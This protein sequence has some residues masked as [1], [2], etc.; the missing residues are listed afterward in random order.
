MLRTFKAWAGSLMAG[1]RFGVLAL[2]TVV[3]IGCSA[4]ALAQTKSFVRDDLA[5]DGVRLEEQLRKEGAAGAVNKQAAQLRRDAEAALA[6]D[7]QRA[8]ALA[9][10]AISADPK[11]APSWLLL[12]RAALAIAPRDNPERWRLQERATVAAYAAYHA[13]QHPAGGGCRA[14]RARRGLRT[15]RDLAARARRLP[16][17][18]RA[19]PTTPAVRTVYEA[20]REEHGFRIADYKVD[21]DAASPRVCFQFSDPLARGKVDFAPFVAVAGAANAAVSVED[22]QLCVDGLK[23]GERYAVVLR[24]GLPSDVG[25]KPAEDRPITRSMSATAPP[26]SASPARTTCCRASGRRASRSSRSTRPSVAAEIFRVGDRNLLSTVRSEDFLAQLGAYRARQFADEN[27]VKIWSGTLDVAQRAQQATS[28]PPFPCMEAVGKLEPGVYVMM[29]RPGR[30]PARV[31]TP[32][33]TTAQR[34]TQWFVVS[35]LGLTAFSG[36]DGVHVLVRSLASAGALDGRRDP[37]RSP[38]TTRCSRRSRPTRTGTSRSIPAWRAARAGLRPA[39][40]SPRTRA[41]DYGFL[42]LGKAAFDLTDRGVKGRDRARAGST[43]SS[44]PSAASIAPARRCISPRCCATRAGVAVA[45]PAADHRRHAARRRR[46]SPRRGRRPGRRADAA[47]RCRCSR[48]RRAARGAL[49]AYADPKGPAI[50]ET[51]FLVE[52]YVPERLERR[53]EAAGSRLC[54]PASP[55]RSTLPCAISTARPAPIS[56]SPANTSSSRRPGPAFPASMATQVGLQDEEFENVAGEIEDRGTTDAQGR[57]TMS[58]DLPDANAPRP[59]EAKIALRVGEAGGRTIERSVVIPIRPQG[60]RCRREEAVRRSRTGR[61]SPVS[62]SSSSRPRG[63]ASRARR[64]RGRS[65]ASTSATNGSTRTAAGASS[66]S[67]RRARSLTDRS[68]IAADAPA[69]ISAPVEWGTY[70]LDVRGRCRGR[71]HQR[72][73]HRRLVRRRH[74]RD[75]RPAGHVARQGRLR[76]RATP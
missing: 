35:D 48:A 54:V 23:H 71:R 75:A 55:R 49:Q 43:P 8:L 57:A 58:V 52:D 6:R 19:R 9:T 21:S 76:R 65:C 59:V 24:Q 1:S 33:R 61:H 22:A 18:P 56:R 44:T 13:R 60:P 46:V 11:L 12:S 31:A 53:A 39:S 3:A 74:G 62:T 27:G 38:A 41:G 36:D 64:P 47:S 42:D 67:A 10:S 32:T 30:A 25:R 15:P 45:G 20:L 63:S 69:R 26:R 40:S 16:R 66:P 70:R 14:R 50:G 37:A 73:L 29:A 5:S 34:A 51:S 4:A 28:S 7:P 2:A 68:N 72:R 17:Q